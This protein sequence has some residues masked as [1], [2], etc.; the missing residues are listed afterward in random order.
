MDKKKKT[1]FSLIIVLILGLIGFTYAY[2][3]KTKT[4]DN[5]NFFMSGSL[6]MQVLDDTSFVINTVGLPMTDGEGFYQNTYHKFSIKNMGSLESSY[7]IIIKEELVGIPVAS[8]VDKTKIKIALFTEE[9]NTLL[10]LMTA[11]Q[12]NAQGGV[13]Y[14]GYL[15]PGVTNTYRIKIWL[16][17]DTTIEESGKVYKAKITLEAKQR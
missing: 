14:Y 12:L 11:A 10:A 4:Q 16:S 2:F 3:T 9:G 1:V 13:I 17:S 5:A 15:S 6:A 7:K 8:Q